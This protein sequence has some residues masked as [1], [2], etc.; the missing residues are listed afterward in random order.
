MSRYRQIILWVSVLLLLAP[1][2]AAQTYTV[3]DLGT[4]PGGSVSQGQAINRQGQVAGYARFSDYNAHGFIWNVR[5]GLQN[6][7]SIPPQ[8]HFGS[9]QAIN[10]YGVVAGYSV[11][12]EIQSEHAVIWVHARLLDLG[13]LQGGTIS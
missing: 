4:F 10:S 1:L 6:L 2:A 9:A 11:Y 7:P 8:E 3:T 12:N 5:L 13:T